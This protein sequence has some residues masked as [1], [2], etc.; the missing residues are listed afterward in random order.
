MEDVHNYIGAS[1]QLPKAVRGEDH[2]LGTAQ[3]PE[4]LKQLWK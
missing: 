4:A 1:G 3:L 2:R